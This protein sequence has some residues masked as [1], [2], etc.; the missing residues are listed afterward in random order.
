P[1]LPRKQH[2]CG[3]RPRFTRPGYPGAPLS[4]PVLCRAEALVQATIEQIVVAAAAETERAD[5][6]VAGAHTAEA[7]R[8]AAV[9]AD[10]AQPLRRFGR[11]RRA[12]TGQLGDRA[13]AVGRLD[14]GGTAVLVGSRRLGQQAAGGSRAS[15]AVRVA[16]QV[17]TA[18]ARA[19]GG[20]AAGVRR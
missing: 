9:R 18:L 17:A 7:Q 20:R 2:P 11:Q 13:L 10:A 6:A 8:G 16:A 1:L 5:R 3:S 14:A 19:S 12:A 15:R 4:M